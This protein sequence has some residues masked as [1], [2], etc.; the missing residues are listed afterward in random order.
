MS[1]RALLVASSLALVLSARS[2]AQ[3]PVGGVEQAVKLDQ[4][5]P[6][7]A[8]ELSFGDRFGRAVAGLRDFDGNGVGD[9]VVG[10]P[11]DDD[12]G[13]DRGAVYV[14]LLNADGSI[15]HEQKIS[16]TQGNFD[17][18]LK[19]GFRFGGAVGYLGDID[20][21]GVPDIVVSA[22]G[23]D[24]AGLH[25][26]AIFVVMLLADGTVDRS[27]KIS[28]SKG[29]FPYTLHEGDLFG[30]SVT[31]L[32]DMNGDGVF[33][34]AVGAPGD[35]EAGLNAGCLYLLFLKKDGTIAGASKITEGQTGFTGDLQQGD[36]FG[37]AVCSLGDHDGNGT[38]DL[39]VG[40]WRDDTGGTDQGALWVLFLDASAQVE[41]HV[42]LAEGLGGFDGKLDT[43]DQFGGSVAAFGD[44]DYDGVIEIAAGAFL[45]D[46]GG[47]DTGAV[48]IL[49]LNADG[50]AKGEQKI[51]DVQGSFAGELDPYDR[52]AC[53]GTVQDM[54]GD[55]K[56]ELAVGAPGTDANTG[57]CWLLTLH[58]AEWIDVGYALAG[59]LGEPKLLGLGGLLPASEVDLHLTKG[60][61]LAPVSLIIGASAIALP[62][63]GGVLVPA[64]DFVCL[65]GTTN[66]VGNLLITGR[67][68]PDVLPGSSLWMQTWMPDATVAGGYSASNALQT[69]AP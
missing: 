9:I 42:K 18:V 24:E 14:V 69:I 34:L 60:T 28:P 59:Q 44:L 53:V 8:G 23:D 1:A 35:D 10:A 19:D 65:A 25:T 20:A 67:W 21:N 29:G 47:A 16:S 51:S 38:A 43:M 27:Q 41:S 11:G 15:K 3:V 46:D 5:T 4:T 54:D 39:V 45:D 58:T 56:P 17:G 66:G 49:F 22:V 62:F 64:P 6:G 7:L 30:R 36:R 37:T 68:P 55:G 48:W 12:G 33:D 50:T 32:P 63:A 40:A 26:G 52:F 31:G 2:G 13:L 61:P 57:A